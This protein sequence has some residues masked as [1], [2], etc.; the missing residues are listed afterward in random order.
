MWSQ[1]I[2]FLGISLICL[3]N[4]VGPRPFNLSLSISRNKEL[5]KIWYRDCYFPMDQRSELNLSDKISEMKNVS[6]FYVIL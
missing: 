6:S 5:W 4:F 1:T 3:I 2:I